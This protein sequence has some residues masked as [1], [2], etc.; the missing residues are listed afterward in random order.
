[1]ISPKK[2]EWKRFESQKKNKNIKKLKIISP[3]SK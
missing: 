2:R 1:M 3:K